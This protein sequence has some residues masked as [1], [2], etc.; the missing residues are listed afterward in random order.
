M[1]ILTED[2]DLRCRDGGRVDIRPTQDFVTIHQ[3]KVLVDSDPEKRPI[4]GCAI[5][6]I[7][8]PCKITLNVTSGYSELLRIDGKRVCLDSIEGKTDGNAPGTV[9]YR[10]QQPGQDFVAEKS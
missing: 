9:P 5:P 7:L 1:K 6:I 3:R 10:V 2:A 8:N 4:K